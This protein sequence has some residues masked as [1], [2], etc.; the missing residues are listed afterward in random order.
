M[1]TGAELYNPTRQIR[2]ATGSVI[3]GSVRGAGHL[4]V[5]VCDECADIEIVVKVVL[6][7]EEVDGV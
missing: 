7:Q 3:A 6:F 4:P 1:C 2:R 5:A